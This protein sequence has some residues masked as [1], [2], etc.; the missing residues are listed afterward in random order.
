VV[1][2]SGCPCGHF[3]TSR[4]YGKKSCYPTKADAQREMSG[5]FL[6]HLV[7][8]CRAASP[9]TKAAAQTELVAQMSGDSHSRGRK[10]S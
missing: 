8:D 9:E 2:M 4:P 1:E 10:R 5:E 7:G 6:R 3:A